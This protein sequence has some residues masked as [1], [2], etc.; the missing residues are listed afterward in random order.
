[1]G[2]YNDNPN[3]TISNTHLENTGYTSSRLPT[4]P[5]SIGDY[6]AY[7]TRGDRY[8]TLAQIYYGNPSLWWIIAACNPSNSSDSLIPE[9]GT[10]IRIP[11]ENRITEIK[12]LYLKV[13]ANNYQ[14]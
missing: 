8:D 6:Y 9:I 1:M 11:N 3:I 4:V 5:L 12:T 10:Q 2:R 13:N 7:T 14:I